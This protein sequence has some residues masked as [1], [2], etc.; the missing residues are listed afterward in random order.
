MS[1]LV[2]LALLALT[3][4]GVTSHLA[5]EEPLAELDDAERAQLCRFTTDLVSLACLDARVTDFDACDADPPWRGCEGD[6]AAWESCVS[7]WQTDGCDA[8]CPSL[9]AP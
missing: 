4:C 2:A 8:P 5:P 3:S 1:R 9:C 6:V 7:A